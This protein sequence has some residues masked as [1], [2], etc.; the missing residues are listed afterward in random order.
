ME[1]FA[2][3]WVEVPNNYAA[4]RSYIVV[5]SFSRNSNSSEM[6]LSCSCVVIW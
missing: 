1:L 4:L 5:L 3:E 2:S 6:N